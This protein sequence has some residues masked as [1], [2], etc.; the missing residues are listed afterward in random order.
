MTNWEY[1]TLTYEN[2]YLLIGD[3]FSL[4]VDSSN[5]FLIEDAST[6]NTQWAYQ[7]KS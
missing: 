5:Y 2:L 7:N 1:Q 6:A 3:G 4:L